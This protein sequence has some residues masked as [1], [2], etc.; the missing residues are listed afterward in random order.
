MEASTRRS[1]FD[2]F[3][4]E[5]MDALDGLADFV[6]EALLFERIEIE[7]AE[8]ARHLDAGAA[9]RIAGAQIGALLRARNFLEFLRLLHR[10]EVEL[11]D[12]VDLLQGFF[13]FCFDLFFGELFVVELND[14]FD[15]ARASAEI[16]A[17]LE[18]FFQNQRSA[19]DGFQ[20]EEL[21]SLDALG[22]GNFTFAR[23][24]RNRTHFAQ[25]HANG[26]VCFFE[27]AGSEIEFAVF[28]SGGFFFYYDSDFGPV[29]TIGGGQRG[30]CA[31]QVFV[32]VNAVT[33]EG[34][35]QIVNFFRGMHLGR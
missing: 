4:F 7:F 30:L 15:G 10:H 16:F 26:I 11:G 29:G 12:F 31:G 33:L 28:R 9:Q 17:D 34:G 22:D 23:K 19:R 32:D 5:E 35:E 1:S 21:A 25:V 27:R 20:D 24:K 3:A 13:C 2:D 8:A 14:F 6:D 18:Q